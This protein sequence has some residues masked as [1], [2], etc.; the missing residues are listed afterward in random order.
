MSVHA[1]VLATNSPAYLRAQKNGALIVPL[2]HDV[3]PITLPESYNAGWRDMFRRHVIAV[4]KFCDHIMYVSASTRK[5]FLPILSGAE[6]A[7][8]PHSVHY[9]GSDFQLPDAFEMQSAAPVSKPAREFFSE[10]AFRLLMVG[11]IEPKKKHLA[12]LSACQTFVG[13]RLRFKASHYRTS[14]AGNRRRLTAGT[15]RPSS[16]AFGGR[17][18]PGS[19]MRP[20]KTWSS[21]TPTANFAYWRRLQRV[22]AFP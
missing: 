10:P 16:I 5:D 4:A 3:L 15:R 8:P 6:V 11:T 21:H 12:V 19:A 22:S 14:P 7:E 9:H 2:L 18:S 17:I 1:C 20:T 13:A